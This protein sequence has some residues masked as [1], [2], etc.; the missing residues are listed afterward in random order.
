MTREF[1]F[2]LAAVRRFFRPEPPLPSVEG[3]DWSEILRLA[4]RH[5]VKAFLRHA[6]PTPELRDV[7]LDLAHFNLTL[8]AELVKLLDLFEQQAL[9]VVSLKGPSL[10]VALYGDQALKSSS[11]LDLLVRPD[12]ALRA[13]RALQANR[14][15][16]ASVPHWP[17]DNAYLRDPNRELSFTD[18]A[19]ALKIDLHWGLLPNY[20]PRLIEDAELWGK[21]RSVRWARTHARTLAPEHQLLFLC[22]HGTKH[23]WER[24]GW[25]CDTARLIQVETELNWSEVFARARRTDTRRMVS[26]GLLLA[27]DLLGVELPSAAAELAAADPHARAMAA[28]VLERLRADSPASAI[29]TARFGIRAFERRS[30]RMRLVVGM[31]CQPTEAEYR[32]LQLPPGL[33]WLYYL[34]RPL[35]L[36]VKYSRRIADR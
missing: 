31:V 5:A 17:A 23:L 29:E 14:Y 15:R 8:S 12:D 11:D 34:L 9:E 1:D 35:R 22:A 3:L 18:P 30:N 26:L 2:L 27:S 19:G 4:D 36:A 25:I 10:G 13:I 20:Y 16:M 24:L 32:A 6:C 21:L 33:Y 28:T 7:A